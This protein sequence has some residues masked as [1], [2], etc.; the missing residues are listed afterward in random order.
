M[1]TRVASPEERVMT[2]SDDAARLLSNA[3]V[4]FTEEALDSRLKPFSDGAREA[5][6]GARKA[7]E[8]AVVAGEELRSALDE[9]D[10][11]MEA[12]ESKLAHAESE[13][14][15]WVRDALEKFIAS[16]EARLGVIER[17]HAE[18]TASAAEG[19]RASVAASLGPLVASAT[20]IVTTASDAALSATRTAEELRLAL[21]D[22]QGAV[23]V[24]RQPSDDVR[25]ELDR[26]RGEVLRMSQMVRQTA[27]RFVLLAATVGA[28]SVAAV[29]W[30]LAR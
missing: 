20:T 9:W 24:L 29:A 19:V 22:A 27:L 26:L 8:S 7:A 15:T 21:S 12:A 17:G 16:A 11:F 5:A 14:A 4:A 28:C 25:L 6:S 30:L 1:T 23:G 13:R 10:R 2:T 18:F 3:V